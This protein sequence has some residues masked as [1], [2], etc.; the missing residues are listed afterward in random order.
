MT[1]Y[2]NFL[3]IYFLIIPMLIV[4]GVVA[5]DAVVNNNDELAD[6]LLKE[7]NR[8]SYDIL[9]F[10]DST[11]SS[12]GACDKGRLGINELF[13]LDSG[14]SVYPVIHN[15]YSPILY[16]KYVKLLSDVRYKP[17]LVIIP[18]TIGSFSSW[19]VRPDT[20]FPLKQIYVDMKLSG[21]ID[22]F[23]YF[24]Y[25]F[26]KKEEKEMV[27]WRESE[28]I[29]GDMKLGKVKD[30]IKEI[31][32]PS[33]SLECN[34]EEHKYK[35]ELTLMFKYAYMNPISHEH[36]II[37]ALDEIIKDL[38]KEGIEVLIYL[39]PLNIADGTKYVGIDFGRR[40]V[41]NIREL[42]S[43]LKSRDV[44]Y[45]D[46]SGILNHM[47]FIDK[48]YASQHLNLSGRRLV[49]NKLATSTPVRKL[50]SDK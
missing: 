9:F 45:L 28:V 27:E 49:A 5:I 39:A 25:R 7:L 24:K 44:S 30:I 10:G 32:I 33:M 41:E 37:K 2:K 40:Y 1:K 13:L 36:E 8:R 12:Y 19:F 11:V 15:L 4:P 48:R 17:R 46:L 26:L 35:K 6:D 47:F 43:F 34:G 3:L 21:K 20:R 14:L 22:I 29:Y 31:N 50:R 42:E 23:R 38:N 18:I 16:K